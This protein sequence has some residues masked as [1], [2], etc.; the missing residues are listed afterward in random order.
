MTIMRA[1]ADGVV[2]EL[3][4]DLHSASFAVTSAASKSCAI[5]WANP[6]PPSA[7]PSTLRSPSAR[8]SSTRSP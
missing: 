3:L 6:S 2:V 8:A 4:R 5:V 7:M 1:R